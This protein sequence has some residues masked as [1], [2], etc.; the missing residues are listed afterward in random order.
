MS[1]V[2]GFR[3]GI[4]VEY[5]EIWEQFWSYMRIGVSLKSYIRNCLRVVLLK[6]ES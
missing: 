5:S 1:L 6:Y 4:V 3:I 2:F